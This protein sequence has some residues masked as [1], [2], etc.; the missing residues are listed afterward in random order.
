M[1]YDERLGSAYAALT[2]GELAAVTRDLPEPAPSLAPA[3]SGPASS[4]VRPAPGQRRGPR[5]A[6]RA[7]T[8]SSRRAAGWVRPC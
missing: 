1:E 4:A 6:S 5:P 8:W 3:S 7:S 2:Y